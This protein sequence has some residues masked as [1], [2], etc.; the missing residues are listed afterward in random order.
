M[1]IQENKGQIMNK[2]HEETTSTL[3]CF[4]PSPVHAVFPRCPNTVFHPVLWFTEHNLLPS[5]TLTIVLITHLHNS[6]LRFLTLPIPLTPFPFPLQASYTQVP[7]S[8]I[9]VSDRKTFFPSPL[10]KPLRNIRGLCKAWLHPVSAH[11]P[12]PYAD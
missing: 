3:Y 4:S 11:S 9:V 10:I 5:L 2:G 12:S 8:Y 1:N 7:N 6:T